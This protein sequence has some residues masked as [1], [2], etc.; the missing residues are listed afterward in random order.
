MPGAAVFFVNRSIRMKAPVSRLLSYGS[1]ASGAPVDKLQKPTS[2]SASVVP[3]CARRVDVDAMLE[4]G[5]RGRHR[6]GADLQPDRSGRGRAG[7]RSSRSHARRTGRRIR[8]ARG[9]RSRSPRAMSSSSS[10]VRVTASP[11]RR[12]TSAPSKV[13]ISLTRDARTEPDH[14]PFARRHAP[15][16]I[17]P[18]NPRNS[19]FGRL[20]HCTGK[21][22]GRSAESLG[23]STVSRCSIRV[24]PSIPGHARRA[25]GDVVAVP[26][27]ERDRDQRGEAEL[28]GELRVIGR[29][30]VEHLAVELDEVHLV[31]REHDMSDAEQ[32]ADQRVPPG[33][34]QDA[35]AGID[36]HTA[37][38]AVDAPVAMLRVYCS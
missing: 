24:G 7:R 21:R 22:N 35:F 16:T 4:R 17:V 27:R 6:A 11:A 28:R 32:R 31:D 36:Q 1:N 13:T 34:R 30:L 19:P 3:Q 8:A 5:D 18:E 38:S 10:K 23:D 37:S 33:L 12:A 15:D 2:F 9:V 25:L 14:A 20:T 29:D 26:G